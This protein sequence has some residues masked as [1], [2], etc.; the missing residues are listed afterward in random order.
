MTSSTKVA[1]APPGSKEKGG[2]GGEGG[3]KKKWK[4][5]QQQ[6]QHQP[7]QQQH[8]SLPPELGGSFGKPGGI[9]GGG[10]WPIRFTCG[11]PGHIDANCPKKIDT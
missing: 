9:I 4:G 1:I 5:N 7:H 6:Q 8:S 10:S 11:L 3:G 2:V